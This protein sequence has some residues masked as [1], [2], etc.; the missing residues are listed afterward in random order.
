MEGS[1]EMQLEHERLAPAHDEPLQPHLLRVMPPVVPG[2]V[3]VNG[4]ELQCGHWGRSGDTSLPSCGSLGSASQCFAIISLA[5]GSDLGKILVQILALLPPAPW[6]QDS[7][8]ADSSVGPGPRV[9]G[10]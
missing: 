1:V 4:P 9:G 6:F 10:R 5:P 8:S 3:Q 7:V 2:A